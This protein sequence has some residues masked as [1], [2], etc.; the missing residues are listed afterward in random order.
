MSDK[1]NEDITTV[2]PPGRRRKRTMMDTPL[3]VNAVTEHEDNMADN[4]RELSTSFTTIYFIYVH[5][6]TVRM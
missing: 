2:T 5:I 6:R 4:V 1:E 3:D